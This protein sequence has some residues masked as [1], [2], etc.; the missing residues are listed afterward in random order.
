MRRL[1]INADDLGIS[2]EVNAKIEDC[3]HRGVITSSTL[4]A[5][6][7]A[8]E[9]G[10]RIAKQYPQISV[11]VHLNLIEFKP[12]TNWDIFQ[13]H[14]V[15]DSE[16]NFIEGAIFALPIDDE[17]KQA[18]FEEWDAQITKVEAA[19]IVP[20]HIDSHQHTHTI[21]ALLE[22]LVRVLDLHKINNVRRKII[23]SIRLMLRDKKHPTV[24][25]DKSKA[26]PVKK[27]NVFYRRF[28]LFTVI[29]ANKH[30]NQKMEKS[31]VMTD[32]FYAFRNFFYDYDA[33]NLGGISGT[34]ELMCHPGHSAF[35]DETERLIKDK[36]W[37][38][39]GYKLISY[40]DL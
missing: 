3:I 23:P 24:H 28:H 33:L 38:P 13:K 16:G 15:I 25:L 26:F 21:P 19:G 40:N 30:W 7:P 5:N 22:P 34:I 39:A 32:S 29:I 37:L 10:V 31:Y 1:I 27:H 11:G 8:F 35:Q 12:L 2:L 20:S 14:G 36:S 18:V 4:M 9:D 17:L 6:A